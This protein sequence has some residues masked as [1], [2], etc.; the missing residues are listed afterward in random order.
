MRAYFCTEALMFH[1]VDFPGTYHAILWRTR[2][3]KFMAMSNY[4]YFKLKMSG[5][6]NVTMVE[7]SFQQ[8]YLDSLMVTI[9]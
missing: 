6:N 2:C 8:A 4:T 3:A 9:S 5:P 1:V 7:T